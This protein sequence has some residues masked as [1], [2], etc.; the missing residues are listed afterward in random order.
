VVK[1]DGSGEWSEYQRMVIDRLDSLKEV[2]DKSE[3]RLRGIETE[4]ALLKLKSSLWGGLAG[5]A[6]YA[7]TFTIQYLQKR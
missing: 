1:P 2:Q 3:V 4:L 6:A 5:I 7:L